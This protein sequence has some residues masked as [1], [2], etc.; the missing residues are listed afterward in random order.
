MHRRLAVAFLFTILASMTVSGFA[1][2]PF[3]PESVPARSGRKFA[4]GFVN[5]VFFWAEVPKEINRDWH[6]YVKVF[7]R[8]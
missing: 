7:P 8:V 1:R 5:T 3:Y 2:G 4:R 6:R